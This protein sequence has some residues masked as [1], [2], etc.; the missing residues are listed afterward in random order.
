VGTGAVAAA[1]PWRRSPR[2][3]RVRLARGHASSPRAWRGSPIR[4]NRAQGAQVAFFRPRRQRDDR[5]SRVTI[6]LA[7]GAAAALLRL[8]SAS[9]TQTVISGRIDR[10]PTLVYSTPHATS[11]LRCRGVSADRA[12]TCAGRLLGP[13][14]GACAHTRHSNRLGARAGAE[15]RA[16]RH[17]PPDREDEACADVPDLRRV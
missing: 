12:R 15:G 4:S 2:A 10:G 16:T 17:L 11:L 13:W 8:P 6:A 14:F 7:V 5:R 9:R 1:R 3:G